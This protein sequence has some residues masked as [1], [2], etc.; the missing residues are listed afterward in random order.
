MTFLLRKRLF[1]RIQPRCIAFALDARKNTA[2]PK[3]E[4]ESFSLFLVRLTKR[5]DLVCI[6]GSGCNF[7]FSDIEIQRFLDTKAFRALDKL[8]TDKEL[9]Q[10]VSLKYIPD[11]GCLGGTSTLSILPLRGDNGGPYRQDIRMR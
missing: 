4:A 2:R 5:S 10:V 8:R 9:N 7:P 1:V 6:H 3:L 11:Q